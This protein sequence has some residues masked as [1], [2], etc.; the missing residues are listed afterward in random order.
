MEVQFGPFQ[1]CRWAAVGP[2]TKRDGYQ[3]HSHD[4]P[5]RVES[6]LR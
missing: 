4:Q 6:R 3:A 1:Y 2:V 5:G